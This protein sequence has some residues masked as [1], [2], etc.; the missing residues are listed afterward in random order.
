MNGDVASAQKPIIMILLNCYLPGFKAGGPVRT[1]ANL[2]EY[3]GDVFDFRIVT[4]D[5]DLHDLSPYPDIATDA[6]QLVGKAKVYYVSPEYAGFMAI[7]RIIRDTPHD[8][9][10]LN[11]YFSFRFS[12]LPVLARKLKLIPQKPIIIAPRGE[13]SSGALEIKSLKKQLFIFISGL[14]GL[15]GN[16]T[17]HASTSFEADDI[18]NA[19]KLK[20]SP[21]TDQ[22]SIAINAPDIFSFRNFSS[23][24]VRKSS[25][26]LKI[27]FL[28]R[29]SPKKNLDYAI[30]ILEKVTVPV[31][32][33][34]YGP[35][36]DNEYWNICE[37]LAHAL[38]DYISVKYCGS[39]DN[40]LVKE[41]FYNYDL[42]LFPTK[43]ENYGHVIAE[44]LSVGTPV[45]LSDQTPWRNL[46]GEKLG[47]D[48]S[49]DDEI[50]FVK[51]IVECSLMTPSERNAWR[52]SI[53]GKILARL[54]DPAICQANCDLFWN[55]LR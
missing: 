1:I 35:I 17:W 11:S 46:S 21:G 15:H 3:L 32:F 41:Y 18:K 39:V 42:F 43:G 40:R 7:N 45:L 52:E 38:P 20:S 9:L 34:I 14:L 23:Q 29:I 53:A 5:R 48:L 26:K 25:D 4:T 16:I 31:E 36:E 30:R 51:R 27:I 33:H 37:R 44:S 28:S 22:I 10:Y 47:W 12:I 54:E 19:L 49:L 55:L 50:E 6:W 8:V 2:V 24:N 13:F